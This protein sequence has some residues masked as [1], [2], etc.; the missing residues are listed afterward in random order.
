[1]TDEDARYYERQENHVK[2]GQN[3]T[4]A[5]LTTSVACAACRELEAF[6]ED[7]ISRLPKWA[8]L[9]WEQHKKEDAEREGRR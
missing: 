3:V 1:M 4:N 9:W 5:Q 6:G 7:A 2:Y 8:Q